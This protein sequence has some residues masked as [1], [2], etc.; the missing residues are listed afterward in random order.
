MVAVARPRTAEYGHSRR[1]LAGVDPRTQR[2][3]T[4]V[5]LVEIED[6]VGRCAEQAI[7][8][9]EHHRLEDVDELGDVGHGDFVGVVVE[10]VQTHTG[11]QRRALQQEALTLSEEAIDIYMGSH[12][13]E[14]AG[15]VYLNQA[16][17]VWQQHLDTQHPNGHGIT[18]LHCCRDAQ[19]FLAKTQ[20]PML[21]CATSIALAEILIATRNP[22]D[23][24]P[25]ALPHLWEGYTLAT[26]LHD[27]PHIQQALKVFR[28]MQT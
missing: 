11:A 12:A 4:A 24:L 19:E 10:D 17:I 20:R 27:A 18:A 26:T 1:R 8:V 21:F 23:G 28:Q 15:E 14:D 3:A 25:H 5:L 2:L 7:A 16:A 6:V 13:L 9:G 22:I